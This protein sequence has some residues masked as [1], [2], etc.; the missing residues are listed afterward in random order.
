MAGLFASGRVADLLLVLLALEAVALLA[1]RRRR[2]G[3]IPAAVLVPNLLAGAGLVLALRTALTGA[4]WAWTALA[5][6]A[7]LAAHLANLAALWRRPGD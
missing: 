5:L 3:G 2:G 6:L 4:H 1:Y 7:A